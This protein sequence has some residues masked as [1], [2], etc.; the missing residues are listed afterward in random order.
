MCARRP[1]PWR[2]SSRAGVRWRGS[3]YDKSEGTL[4][5]ILWGRRGC[6][7]YKVVGYIGHVQQEGNWIDQDDCLD[8]LCDLWVVKKMARDHTAISI[9]GSSVPINILV[10]KDERNG[11]HECETST[12]SFQPCLATIWRISSQI[13]SFSRAACVIRKLTGISS[14]AMIPTSWSPSSPSFGFSSAKNFT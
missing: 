14:T 11:T 4:K 9:R 2:Q 7:A 3:V 5:E 1:C 10:R 12:K 8:L 6:L 13:W